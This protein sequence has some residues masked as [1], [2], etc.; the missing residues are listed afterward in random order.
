[1]KNLQKLYGI[2]RG[3]GLAIVSSVI[4]SDQLFSLFVQ[5]DRLFNMT[6]VVK[7]KNTFTT[8]FKTSRSG[9][10]PS[11]EHLLAL[12]CFVPFV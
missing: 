8:T 5:F 1:M 10:Q 11:L 6:S 2:G 3:G 12:C 4:P 9:L 7:T